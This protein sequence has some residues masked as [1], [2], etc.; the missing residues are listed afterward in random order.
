MA[1]QP[2]VDPREARFLASQAE[3][4]SSNKIAA[5]AARHSVEVDNDDD[6]SPA[7][8]NEVDSSNDNNACGGSIIGSS[9]EQG[10]QFWKSFR[11]ICSGF[12]CQIDSLLLLMPSDDAA[13]AS[14]SANEISNHEDNVKAHY[15]TAS[16]RNEGRIKLDS[17]LRNVRSLQ[18]HA[19]SS[20]SSVL[21]TSQH[22]GNS[23]DKNDDDGGSELLLQSILQNPMPDVTQTDMRLISQ[24]I[25][26]ILKRID[27]ARE[28]ICPKEKFV[29]KRYRKAMEE[30]E[31][32][33]GSSGGGGVLCSTTLTTES[34]ETDNKKNN[35]NAE[36]DQGIGDSK[37]QQDNNLRSKYGGVLENM[38]NCTVELS[39]NGTILVNETP[40]DQLQYYSAPR[41][42]AH[43]VHPTPPHHATTQE[44]SSYLFQNLQNV[45]VLLHGSRPS[46]HLQHIQ[47]CRIYVCEPTLGPVH[48]T[49]CQSSEIRC[50]CYQLRVHDSNDVSFGVWVRSG[51][52]IEDCKGMIFDG[53]YYCNDDGSN[54]GESPNSRLFESGGGGV[55]R[56]MFWDVKDFN[57]LRALRKSPN[58]VV[59]TKS[60][61]VGSEEHGGKVDSTLANDISPK[62]A[63]C[64]VQATISSDSEDEL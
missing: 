41:P 32:L 12:Q 51:P 15:A 43:A 22:D 55:G 31:R 57:W 21:T 40:E 16:R 4:L 6:N 17:I 39:S 62:D 23:N 37:N 45:T 48:V 46:L 38:T 5:A 49:D 53:N 63:N 25:D 56:N 13:A 36:E 30:R 52:I 3:R 18:R 14:K 35:S 64:S 61:V 19:L 33:G 44:S 2:V 9:K 34:T 1:H 26:K 28:I 27:D 58:F 50:S 59:I 42:T 54:D 47:N 8:V 11:S 7:L 20:S 10:H 29:F 24:E 60:S